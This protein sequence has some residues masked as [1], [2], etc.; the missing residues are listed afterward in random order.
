ML[1]VGLTGGIGVGKTTVAGLLAGHG[2]VVVDCDLLGR[3]VVEPG[4]LA[5]DA[6]V[7]RFGPRVVRDDGSVDRPALAR[8][9]FGHPD[10]LADLN[11]IT[12]PAIDVGIARAIAVAPVDA[13]VVLDMAVLV[14][15]RLGRGQYE[16]VVVVEAPLAT[17]LTRL[18]ARGLGR[19]EALA[20]IAAQA[21]DADRRAVG[22]LFVDNGGDEAALAE[23]VATL[24]AELR[25]RA[26]GSER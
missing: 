24:W 2:A 16:L 4:G 18:A 1:V 3:T 10:A 20:R 6:V 15:T 26:A 19:D 8:Q 22:D 9:V 25:R 21:S 5:H 13:V 12:H 17:R 11:A 7:A 14:E 23:R